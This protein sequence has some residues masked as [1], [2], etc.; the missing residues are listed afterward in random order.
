MGCNS[1]NNRSNGLPRGCNNNGSC[2][3]GSCGTF[4]VFDWLADISVSSDSF[5]IVEVRF[6]NG[7]KEYFRNNDL[8]A[9][10]G[11]PIITES[12]KGYDIGEITLTG[13][14]VKN[15]MKKKGINLSLIH[16]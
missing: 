15:Q 13:E 4:T 8:V 14:L 12:E 6:K 5:K 7:R 11:N 1:C 2:A 3:S 10:K 16:I 9:S